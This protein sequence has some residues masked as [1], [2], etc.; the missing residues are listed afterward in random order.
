MWAKSAEVPRLIALR[1]AALVAMAGGPPLRSNISL[2]LEVHCPSSGSQR[3]GD[4]DNFVTGVC[5]GL[6]AADL[7]INSDP[8]WEAPECETVRPSLCMAIEDDDAVVSIIAKKI[9][10]ASVPW[11]RVSLEGE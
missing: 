9:L 6:M 8:R 4:L 7:R 2:E 10:G 11:Y 3:I 5:D 1:Q